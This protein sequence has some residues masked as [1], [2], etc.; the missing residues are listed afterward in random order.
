MRIGTPGFVGA[1]LTEGREARA[2]SQT[3]L[4]E[5]TGIKSQ[6]I[7]HYEQ[8]RQSPSPEALELLCESLHLPEWFFLRPVTHGPASTVFFRASAAP[9]KVGPTPGVVPL[10]PLLIVARLVQP[11]ALGVPAGAA[12]DV[13]GTVTVGGTT[14]LRVPH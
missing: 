7:S 3:A 1:R 11:G 5:L 6:S 9:A 13:Q 8:G 12:G 4:A 14:K 2:L 10:K